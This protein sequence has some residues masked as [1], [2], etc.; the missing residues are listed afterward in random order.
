MELKFRSAIAVHGLDTGF[1]EQYEFVNQRSEKA[2]N[3]FRLPRAG[4]NKTAEN[5]VGLI[6]LIGRKV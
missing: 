1:I 5:V 2:V 6:A 4:Y 3:V